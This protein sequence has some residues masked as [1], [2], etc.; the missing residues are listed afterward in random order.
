[1]P[2]SARSGAFTAPQRLSPLALNTVEPKGKRH[3]STAT[4]PTESP[5]HYRQQLQ[6]MQERELLSDLHLFCSD[7]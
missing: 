2:G 1:M 7:I 6:L 3:A 5:Y 4:E